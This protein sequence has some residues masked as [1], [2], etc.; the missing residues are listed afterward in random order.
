GML[1]VALHEFADAATAY[2]G[3]DHSD[4]TRSYL[5]FN[6][7]NYINPV[8][9][10][11]LPLLFIFLG[12][13]G[14]PGG[15]VYLRRDLVRSRAWQSAIS[16]AGPLMNVLC[17]AI[18]VLAFRFPFVQQHVFLASAL[19]VLALL[20][21][22]AVVLNLLPIPPLDGFGVVAPFLPRDF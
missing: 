14:L 20:E 9:S 18:I 12:G 10:I 13:I 5:T 11:V 7:L 2:L 17:V 21:V 3:G 15:A 4:S 19:A 22:Y 6:P 8:L 16:L 1:S